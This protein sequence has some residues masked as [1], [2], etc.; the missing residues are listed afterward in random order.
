MEDVKISVVMPAYNNECYVKESIE[1]ILNQSLQEIELIV[2]DDCSSDS[3]YDIIQEL[4]KQDKRI[5]HFRNKERIGAANTRNKGM[6]I[7]K[8]KYLY[9]FDSDDILESEV[10]KGAYHLLENNNLDF[11]YLYH[12]DID[13]EGRITRRCNY[14]D[15]EERVQNIYDMSSDKIK[16]VKWYIATWS[17]IYRRSF[18]ESYDIKYQNLP[19]LNDRYHDYIAIFC[20]Q[21]VMWLV[22]ENCGVRY[23]IH[24]STTKITNNKNVF[25]AYSVYLKIQDKLMSL[26]IWDKAAPYYYEALLFGIVD[27]MERD[28]DKVRKSAFA[29][30]FSEVGLKIIIER[31]PKAYEQ[32]PD[33]MHTY[34]E[35]IRKNHN[36]ILSYSHYV[37]Y[38]RFCTSQKEANSLFHRLKK[39]RVTL[40]VWGCGAYGMIVVKAL[41]SFEIPIH[42]LIDK[43]LKEMECDGVFY[44]INKFEQVSKEV[45]VLFITTSKYYDDIVEEVRIVNGECEVI[46]VGSMLDRVKL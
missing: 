15:V 13:S 38:E 40:G 41:H 46:N 44:E 2:I 43:T 26:L 9:C 6:D 7:A 36:E 10:L 35:Y 29:T 37:M 1:S 24:T 25:Y 32:L 30:F 31:D 4:G 28:S 3:T 18:I 27:L 20:A 42:Y 12:S 34:C 16:L 45:D 11:V 23:R 33:C 19:V 21:R 5:S 22:G 14:E 8:G 39:E 17:K